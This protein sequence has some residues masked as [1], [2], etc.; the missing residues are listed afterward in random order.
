MGATTGAVW[1]PQANNSHYRI[2]ELTLPAL[3]SAGVQRFEFQTTFLPHTAGQ[4]LIRSQ[5]QERDTEI[6]AGRQIEFESGTA[7]E[8][9]N[10]TDQELKFTVMESK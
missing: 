10:T 8:I 9:V 3:T 6:N 1:N 2:T 5:G 4:L 7:S